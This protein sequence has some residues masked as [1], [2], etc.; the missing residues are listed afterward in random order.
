MND[1]LQA[2]AIA[3]GLDEEKDV[4]HKR[5]VVMSTHMPGVSTQCFYA[6]SI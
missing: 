5:W 4:S 2:L 6:A 1:E 3:M